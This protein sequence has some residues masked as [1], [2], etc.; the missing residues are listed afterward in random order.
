ME[1]QC[2]ICCNPCIQSALYQLKW[3]LAETLLAAE[4]MAADS[5]AGTVVSCL[6]WGKRKEIILFYTRN[7]AHQWW[8]TRISLS[9]PFPL[10]LF[11]GGEEFMIYVYDM[12]FALNRA[13]YSHFSVISIDFSGTVLTVSCLGVTFSGSPLLSDCVEYFAIQGKY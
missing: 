10:S 2:V 9:P 1:V 8:Y 12:P 6:R 5:P 11:W 4:S 3:R 7:T 13:W